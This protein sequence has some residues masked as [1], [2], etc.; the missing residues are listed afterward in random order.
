MYQYI[1]V[2]YMY[3]LS[4]PIGQNNL[5]NPVV[6]VPPPL[7]PLDPARTRAVHRGGPVPVVNVNIPAAPVVAAVVPPGPVVGV[8][9][10]GGG[11]APVVAAAVPP[12]PVIAAAAAPPVVAVPLAGARARQAQQQVR[13]QMAHAAVNPNNN[14]PIVIADADAQQIRRGGRGPDLNGALNGMHGLM[15]NAERMIARAMGGRGH[16]NGPESPRRANLRRRDDITNTMTKLMTLRAMLVQQNMA[17][18]LVDS[19]IH[20]LMNQQAVIGNPGPAPNQQA[21]IG[22]RGPAP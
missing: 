22:I 10:F 2:T 5:A 14:Q 15:G 8:P 21:G 19:Q 12:A 3:Q 9:Q 11:G 20:E 4:R 18:N 16:D 1:T 13:Q 7:P 6:A 17:T